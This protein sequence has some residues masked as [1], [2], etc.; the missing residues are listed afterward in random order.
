MIYDKLELTAIYIDSFD[1]LDHKLKSTFLSYVSD[2]DDLKVAVDKMKQFLSEDDFSILQK[3]ANNDYLKELIS[4]IERENAVAI[5]KYSKTY[6]EYLSEVFCP[7]IVL[8]SKGN[9]DLLNDKNLS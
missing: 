8:Y 1:F 5:T 2:G 7:P 6:P 4:A 9:L 3:C